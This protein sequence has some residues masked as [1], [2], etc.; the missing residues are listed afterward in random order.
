MQHALL[1]QVFLKCLE[2]SVDMG[3]MRIH[4]KG[5]AVHDDAVVRFH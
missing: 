2:N 4:R 3:C 5:F 1:R